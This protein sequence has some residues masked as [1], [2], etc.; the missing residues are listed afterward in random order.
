MSPHRP[1]RRFDQASQRAVIPEANVRRG[2]LHLYLRGAGG[3]GN[4][5]FSGSRWSRPSNRSVQDASDYLR[6]LPQ[7]VHL[8]TKPPSGHK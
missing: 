6:N 7:K 2:K 5:G 8:W 1:L 4:I 3:L